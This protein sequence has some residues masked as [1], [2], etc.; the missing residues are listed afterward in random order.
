MEP[1]IDQITEALS[2]RVDDQ[3]AVPAGA[4]RQAARERGWSGRLADVLEILDETDEKLAYLS[5]GR[6]PEEVATWLSIWAESPLTADQIRL[7]TAAGGWE[8]D[9]FVVLAGAGL[10][11]Q[12]LSL[13]DG[14]IR[15]VRGERAG[16]WVSDE[17]ALAEE[18]DL[19][20]AVRKVLS[21]EEG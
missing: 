19:L 12:F 6:R 11:E 7:V 16:A 2:G 20:D 17:L 9:P 8:P 14:T 1:S 13:P 5:G 15:H 10:L 3:G 4:A 21:A 18:K